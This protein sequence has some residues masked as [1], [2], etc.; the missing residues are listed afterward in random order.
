[1]QIYNF[2]SCVLLCVVSLSSLANVSVGVRPNYQI[3]LLAPSVLKSRL[4]SCEHKPM[5]GQSFAI[6]HRGAPLQFPE[7]TRESY[8]AAAKM[9]AGALECDVTFTKD[10]QLVCR[11][12]QCDLH[13]TTDILLQPSLAKTC[14]QPFESYNEQ[15]G[16]AASALCCTSDITVDEFLTLKGKM[17]GVNPKAKTPA[18][19]VQGTEKWRTDLYAQTGTLMTHKQSIQLFQ[20]LDVKMVPELKQPMVEMPFFGLTQTQYATMLFNEYQQAGVKWQDVWLQSFQFSDIEFWLAHPTIPAEQIVWLDERYE[21]A[22]FNANDPSTWQPSM[23]QL[24]QAGL[25][26]LA[27]PIWVLVQL[28]EQGE[29]IPSAYALAAKKAGLNLIAWSFERSPPRGAM[30]Y[31]QSVQSAIRHSGDKLVVLDV[32]AQQVGVKAVFSDWPATAAYYANCLDLT[33]L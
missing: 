22:E 15:T 25:K 31:Y 4:K 19:F 12:S 24:A 27:P 30:W 16:Q 33:G 21:Q 14:R 5:K 8:I 1:M 9:G 23:Q 3:E 2:L 32:L 29:I 20:S 17:D 18:E 28:S 11:H 13:A 6:G 26:N 7:H 10:A